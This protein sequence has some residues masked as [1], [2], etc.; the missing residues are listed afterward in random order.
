MNKLIKEKYPNLNFP[1]YLD[2]QA[3]TPTDPRVIDVMLPYFNQKYGNPHSR[4]HSFAWQAEEA[5]ELARQQVADLINASPKEIIFTSGATESNNLAIQGLAKFYG[6]IKNHIITLVTEHKC[7]LDS[8]RHLELGGFEVTYLPVQANGIDDLNRLEES[9]KDSTLLV[10]A[11]AVN[12][13]IGVIQPLVEI[14]SICRKK[15]VFFHSDIAQ[16]FG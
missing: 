3:T 10:S 6:N 5:C 14:G 11:M 8:C 2:N 16:G 9:I 12:N 1:I 4:N 15:G 7:V 13:E